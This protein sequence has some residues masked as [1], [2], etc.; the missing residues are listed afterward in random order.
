[1]SWAPDGSAFV[2]SEVIFLEPGPPDYTSH[3]IRYAFPGGQRTDLSEL[4]NLE[5]ADMAESISRLVQTE[6][7]LQ[8]TLSLGARNQRMNLFD[9]LG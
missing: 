9:F 4:S 5:D 8:A 3:L 6:T 1:M 2:T 7:G